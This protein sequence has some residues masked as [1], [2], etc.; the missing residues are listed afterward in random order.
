MQFL[1]GLVSDRSVG[2]VATDSV[3][4]ACCRF[5]IPTAPELNGVVA[6]LVVTATSPAFLR[7]NL[8]VGEQLL[9]EQVR[10]FGELRLAREQPTL[11]VLAP[12][13]RSNRNAPFESP[14]SEPRLR[15]SLLPRWFGRR[16]KIGLVGWNSDFGLGHVN[17]DLAQ[18]LRVTR[19]LVPAS[20]GDQFRQLPPRCQIAPKRLADNE[21]REWLTGLEVVIFVE[22]PPFARLTHV[23]RQARVPVV[24]IPDWEWIRPGLSWLTE[25]DLMLCPTRHTYQLM[26]NWKR[27]F[28]FSWDI[29]LVPWPIDTNRF[30]FRPR[31]RCERFVFVGG[32]GGH[33][34]VN[35]ENASVHVRRKGLALI[36]QAARMLPQCQFLVFTSQHLHDLPANLE[37]R[38]LTEHNA[39][40]YLAGDVCVQPS[41]WE[42]IGLPLLECQSA[43]LPLI[44]TDTGPMNEY[45]PLATIPISGEFI[46]S[47]GGSQNIPVPVIEPESL[48]QVLKSVYGQSILNASHRARH[49]VEQEH[50]WSTARKTIHMILDRL[51]STYER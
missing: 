49:F 31:Q 23:A 2:C 30:R 45:Q 39:D 34:A 8:T 15:Q 14:A 18:Q 21:L 26:Q 16:H 20:G 24:C 12:H 35:V 32:K 38:R 48:A 47:L 27:R 42:G 6:S 36:V 4:R 40:L 41:Y 17:R 13:K 28:G 19:W 7:P 3:C 46:G 44:T 29:D 10:E 25:V 51:L 1:D 33:E 11:A 50:A 22:R 5:S 9:V 43:G 37:L